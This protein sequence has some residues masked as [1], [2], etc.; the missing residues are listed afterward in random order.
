MSSRRGFTLIELLVVIA[1]IGIL[2]AILL[3]ALARAR[4]AARRASCQNNLKQMGLIL[5]MYAN[6]SEGEKYPR[7]HAGEPWKSP[8]DPVPLDAGCGDAEGAPDFGPCST[9]LYPEYLTDPYVLVCP[10]DPAASV[11]EGDLGLS[12]LPVAGCNYPGYISNSDMS[13]IYFGYCIDDGDG[14]KYGTMNIGTADVSAQLVTALSYVMVE[15][16]YDY[17]TL[18]EDIGDMAGVG[19]GG[20]DSVYRL[21]EG[22]ERFLISDI[23]NPAASN[24][25][26]SE[27]A[28]MFDVIST[29]TGSDAHFNHVPGGVNALY[30]DGHV[31]FLKYPS[32]FPASAGFAAVVAY[33]AP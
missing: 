24:M 30:L 6:E 4:E 19:N 9:Q 11:T 23:N 2:A 20:G 31:A 16:P 28:I 26:Q 22:I 33:A 29:D 17:E 8:T 10:S 1:I 7:V 15:H 27:L 5:K 18:E 32:E 21:R 3:P 12:I 14:G 13:Y 25:A